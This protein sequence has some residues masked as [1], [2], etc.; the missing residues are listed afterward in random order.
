MGAG[1]D[2]AIGILATSPA[3]YRLVDDV[4]QYLV[5]HPDVEALIHEQASSFVVDAVDDLRTEAARADTAL[6]RVIVGVR[7]RMRRKV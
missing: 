3:F 7:R 1:L 2:M 4:V 6:D 5:R